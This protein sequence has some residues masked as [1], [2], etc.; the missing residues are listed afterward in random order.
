MIKTTPLPTEWKNRMSDQGFTIDVRYE[1]EK[2]E[3]LKKEILSYGGEAVVLPRADEYADRLTNS[4]KFEMGADADLIEGL[5]IQCHANSA[6]NFLER[7]HHIVTGYALSEDGVWRQHTWNKDKESG[8]II[9]T[10]V[11]RLAYYGYQLDPGEEAKFADENPQSAPL[12]KPGDMPEDDYLVVLRPDLT[13][14]T[15]SNDED[16][17]IY[18]KQLVIVDDDSAIRRV[19]LVNCLHDGFELKASAFFEEIGS[20]EEAEYQ[21]RILGTEFQSCDPV[22]RITDGPLLDML[23]NAA[24]SKCLFHLVDESPESQ[25]VWRFLPEFDE[26][27]HV[28]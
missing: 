18:L 22:V 24:N 12:Y 16:V 26:D 21:T 10:T 17:E 6:V 2:L 28:R 27:L 15:V 9:E 8:R 11:P 14:M 13:E 4:G 1:D 25:N 3:K 5:P 7:G 20:D 19:W 23:T